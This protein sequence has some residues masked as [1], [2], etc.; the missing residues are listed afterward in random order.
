M[1]DRYF[2]FSFSE[3][4]PSGGLSDVR[5]K[6]DT[7]EDAIKD[8]NDCHLMFTLVSS[9]GWYLWDRLEDK[10]VIDSETNRVEI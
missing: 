1:K 6:Y 4:Y 9:D 5:K 3:Y 2:L 10:F 8:L 7:L